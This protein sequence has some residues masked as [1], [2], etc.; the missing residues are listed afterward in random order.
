MLARNA[1]AKDVEILVLRHE[2]AV[3]CRQVR[4]PRPRWPDWAI[5]S[6]F[7]RLLPRQLRVHRIITP[8]TLL[9]WHR[10][11]ISRKW[12]YPNR[13]GRHLSATTSVSWCY[14]PHQGL[15]L[16]QHPPTY[17]S[18]TVIPLDA[19]I[20]RHRLLGGVI[21]EYRRAA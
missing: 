17:D 6:A 1:A 2:V 21:K 8:A 9:A 18:A 14:D 12:I 11:L 15:K 16:N 5:L 7:T 19:P 3:L 13:S 20:R 4:R 10:R